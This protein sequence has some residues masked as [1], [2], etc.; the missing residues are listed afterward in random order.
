MSGCCAGQINKETQDLCDFSGWTAR[1]QNEFYDVWRL[2]L[3]PMQGKTALITGATTGIGRK[4]AEEFSRLGAT[5]I[6]LNRPSER[7]D[8][9]LAE[10]SK[11]AALAGETSGSKMA[12]GVHHVDCDLQELESVRAAAERVVQQ[13]AGS[14]SELKGIDYLMLNA[15]LMLTEDRATPDG[16]DIQ[17]QVNHLSQFLLTKLVWNLVELAAT[18]RGD[19]RVIT[20]T[21]TAYLWSSCKIL[22]PWPCFS[23]TIRPKYMQKNGGKLGGNFGLPLAPL[24]PRMYR[25]AQ[26]KL[27]NIVFT[28]ALDDRVRKSAVVGAGVGVDGADKKAEGGPNP[29]IRCI[30]V[31]PGVC[32]ETELLAASKR[33]KGGGMREHSKFLFNLGGH[34]IKTATICMLMAVVHPDIESGSLVEPKYWHKL[35]MMGFGRNHTHGP[36]MVPARKAEAPHF[37]TAEKNKELLWSCSLEA[38]G[39]KE[40]DIA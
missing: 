31:M 30:T 25:Y 23:K 9:A 15:G 36:P 16:F 34:G 39:E 26:S 12:A 22:S 20:N 2:R 35:L 37:M 29:K 8:T 17:M 40:F 11:I 4:L 6:M 38:V 18:T 10:V 1:S 21:S 3:K 27:A 24:G 14:G 19:C 28:A 33:G 7:A 5:V 32:M 13:L